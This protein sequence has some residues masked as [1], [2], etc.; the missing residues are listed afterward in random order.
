[1]HLRKC[2]TANNSKTK[3]HIDVN[4]ASQ[5]VS[6]SKDVKMCKKSKSEIFVLK[7]F[8][9]IQKQKWQNITQK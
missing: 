8:F 4:S 3:P 6:R 5:G 1:M 2:F 7:S 9:E